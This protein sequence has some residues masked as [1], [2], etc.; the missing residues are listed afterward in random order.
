MGT[1]KGGMRKGLKGREGE[2][3]GE[4]EKGKVRIIWDRKRNGMKSYP[5]CTFNFT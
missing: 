4:G 1:E 5:F 3:N 2:R